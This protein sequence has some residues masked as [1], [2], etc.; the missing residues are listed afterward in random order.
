M[1][2]LKPSKVL[3]VDDEYLALDLLEEF[4]RQLPQASLVAKCKSAMEAMTV[5]QGQEVDVMFLDVQMPSLSGIDFLKG[6]H[7]PPAT[8]FTT[9]YRDFAVDAFELRATDYLVKP[10]SF[11]RFAR[12]FIIYKIFLPRFARSFYYLQN[13][14]KS[15]GGFLRRGGVLIQTPW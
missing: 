5:L 15:Q 1:P 10:F 6:L 3:L 2:D 8:V 13:S 7:A 4:L 9:A 12:S 11:A 14:Q